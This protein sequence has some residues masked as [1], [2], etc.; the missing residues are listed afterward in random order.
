MKINLS[1]FNRSKYFLFIVFQIIFISKALAEIPISQQPLSGDET[2]EYLYNTLKKSDYEKITEYQSRIIEFDERNPIFFFDTF[3]PYQYDAET[4][5]FNTIVYLLPS[6]SNS[7][8]TY[9]LTCKDC[10]GELGNDL[11]FK[12]DPETAE[13]VS[14]FL[15]ARTALHFPYRAEGMTDYEFVDLIGDD[16]T[17]YYYI[18]CSVYMVTIYDERD[19]KIYLQKGY[20]DP[21]IIPTT[22]TTTTVPIDPGQNPCIAEQLYGENSNETKQL[23]NYRDNVL[24]KT[25]LGQKVTKLY[26]EWSPLLVGILNNN[27]SLRIAIKD[28][29]DSFI[30]SIKKKH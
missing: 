4:E 22:T 21:K 9:F 12:I 23:K 29:L 24:N 27:E 20:I 18:Y 8:G 3:I 13:D 26:Y 19:N 14:A 7:V 5:T 28:F 6:Y 17:Y 30:C 15:R 11:S 16:F 1:K 10:W 25:L 2:L